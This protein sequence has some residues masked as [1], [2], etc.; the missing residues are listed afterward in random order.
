[1]PD[2]DNAKHVPDPKDL[3]DIVPSVVDKIKN[4]VK[5]RMCATILICFNATVA[6][7]FFCLSVHLMIT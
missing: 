1:M 4:D 2:E 5:K 6:I 7:V 3:T